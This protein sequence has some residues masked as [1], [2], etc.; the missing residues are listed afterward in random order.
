MVLIMI[1]Q[2]IPLDLF[3]NPQRQV[4]DTWLTGGVGH[5]I[6]PITGQMKPKVSV[7]WSDPGTAPGENGTNTDNPNGTHQTL[8]YQ[9]QL[10]KN[11]QNS[12][13]R[14]QKIE[15]YPMQSPQSLTDL[16]YGF[17]K[18]GENPV[19]NYTLENGALYSLEMIGTHFHWKK[20][21]GGKDEREIAQWDINLPKKIHFVTD[22][23]TRVK[24]VDKGLQVSWEYIPDM[25]Y[26]LTYVE[27]VKKTVAEVESA[28]METTITVS[29]KEAKALEKNG[30]V[31]YVLENLKSQQAYSMY[32]QFGKYDKPILG[33]IEYNTKKDASGPKVVSEVTPINIKVTPVGGGMIEIYWGDIAGIISNNPLESI[34]ILA[35]PEGQGDKFTVIAQTNDQLGALK[36]MVIEEPIV[37]TTYKVVFK[38]KN[39]YPDKESREYF[40]QVNIITI[41]PHTPKIPKPFGPYVDRKDSSVDPTDYLVTGD[42]RKWTDET[43]QEN[44]ELLQDFIN[45]AFHGKKQQNAEIQVTWDIP[46][47]PGD[48]ENNDYTLRYD[49]WVV[50]DMDA[51]KGDMK[52][53]PKIEDSK[54]VDA[55]DVTKL[56][57]HPRYTKDVIGIKWDITQYLNYETKQIEPLKKNKT[58]YIQVVAKRLIPSN[59][60]E[61]KDTY[62]ESKPAIVA[63]TI[64]KDGNIY[65]PPVIGKPPL[66]I[67]EDSITK[68]SMTVE[69]RTSWWE[70]IAKELKA[71]EKTSKTEQ[72]LAE[73]GSSEVYTPQ[74]KNPLP[75]TT[76]P[77]I[78][79]E[80]QPEH[81]MNE[82]F[83][84][85]DVRI[86]RTRVNSYLNSKH[87]TTNKDYF[88]EQYYTK[89]VV[90]ED[91]VKYQME[92][93]EY[94]DLERRMLQTGKH[95]IE[96]WIRDVAPH[97]E[98]SGLKWQDVTP[99]TSNKQKWLEYNIT[100]VNPGEKLKPN[101]RYVM[102]MRAYR[103]VDGEKVM[104]SFPTYV[105]GTTLTDFVGPEPVP[106][107]PYL[108]L[109]KGSETDTSFEVYWKYNKDFNYE[110]RYSTG[111]D[112]KKAKVWKFTIVDTPND[113]DRANHKYYFVDGHDAYLTLNGLFP[114][115]TYN[116]WIKALQKKGNLESDYSTPVTA[117]TK[118][119]QVPDV[120]TGLGPGSKESLKEANRN[121]DPI[122][123]DY[124]T[125]EWTKNSND[126]GKQTM[127]SISKWYEY[128]VEFADNVE[129]IDSMVVT[130]TDTLGG[131]SSAEFIA[132][133]LVKFN[134]LLAN[135]PYYVRVKTRIVMTDTELKKEISKESGYC[136]WVRIITLKSDE[137]YDGG[138]NDNI[139]TYPD[140]VEEDYNNGIW[141]WE[142]VDVQGIITEIIRTNDYFFTIDMDLYKGRHDARIRRVIMPV[143]VLE[144]LVGQKKEIKVI[145]HVA[146]YRIPAHALRY[147][148]EKSQA[149]DKIQFEFETMLA[150]DLQDIA[151]PY[152]YIVEGGEKLSVALRSNQAG[153]KAIDYFDASIEVALKLKEATSYQSNTYKTYTYDY[154][155]GDW[156]PTTYTIQTK[157]DGTYLAYRADRTGIYTV[158]RVDTYHQTS[159]INYA[160]QQLLAS[161]HIEKLG[162]TYKEKDAVHSDQYMN[163]MMG[164][165]QG[166][167]DINLDGPI[168]SGVRDK[169]RI[170][171][172][173]TPNSSGYI[174]QEIAI[175]GVVRLYE[176]KTGYRVKPSTKTFTGVSPAYQEA[177]S[178]AY[179]L[180]LITTINPQKQVSYGELCTWIQMV[181]PY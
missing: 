78:R 126:N 6:D 98:K 136:K 52:H 144:A 10:D 130:V 79:Y 49:L 138:D 156:V 27:G 16:A 22:F 150:Y 111:D 87:G 70:V 159:D 13:F 145:T 131:E 139:V 82:L 141:E 11:K 39:G 102:M 29:A 75:V 179:A 18:Y 115:T 59:S 47:V 66:R 109:K 35:K 176:M 12:P 28:N 175:N 1:I 31:E 71:Y 152:P 104:Q 4:I 5:I 63:I 173:Y 88:V 124:I 110:V 84:E 2:Y 149:Q 68:E 21:V 113:E 154:G 158:Y 30:R 20:G 107:T 83:E 7:G 135:K 99:L 140:K 133:N 123:K 169:A 85:D 165:A 61:V 86:L 97:D 53:L 174:T 24:V 89:D 132:K 105:I 43:G 181:L 25:E 116:V 121:M 81:E 62:I 23:D 167:K 129:F 17:D 170:T 112:P 46:K 122:G 3:A 137:E 56:I 92:V 67:K 120:P 117:R 161:Y 90:L 157:E 72:L 33:D 19:G 37:N 58:Y 76:G 103:V 60:S 94:T 74:I 95:T 8:F 160:M 26:K 148:L 54:R 50:D 171:K 96:E 153:K 163:L 91:D 15:A 77:A 142:I 147:K 41:P 178:K 106:T 155:N 164:I 143:P 93:L 108:Y 114:G 38:F 151:K 80:P 172:I 180:G 101:T 100:E 166:S 36:S 57:T 44:E 69:W 34:Q 119:I 162:T 48:E 45:N 73:V 55:N 177:V 42:D 128:D 14:S 64:D 134:K 40:Y 51:Y 125:V 32:V 168:S 118:D 65:P 146:T 9:V 127:G